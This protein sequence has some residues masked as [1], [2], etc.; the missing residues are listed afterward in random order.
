MSAGAT[1]APASPATAGEASTA[2]AADRAGIDRTVARTRWYPIAGAGDCPPRHVFAGRLLGRE[3]AVWR[4]DDGHV[5]AWEN[6]C[7][8]RG[9]RLTIGVNDG[10]DLVCRYHGWRYASRSA[11][12]TYIPAHPADAPARTIRNTAYPAVERDGL[13]WC[14][15]APVG[16]PP[17]LDDA[18]G[19]D[20][21]ALRPVGI[22][23]SLGAVREALDALGTALDPGAA[24]AEAVQET[25]DAA[26]ARADVEG[27]P[28]FLLQPAAADRT[29]VHGFVRR[30][31][32]DARAGLVALRAHDV[33]L[34]ALRRKVEAD[35][36]RA[37][38][39]RPFEVT[40]SRVDAALAA[41]PVRV[42]RTGAGAEAS[43]IRVRV[44][45]LERT[46]TD[47]VEL[48]LVPLDADG[49]LPA[50]LPGSHVDLHLPNGQ[51][52]QY[53]LANGP[54]TADRWALGVQRA[55]DSRGGSAW[56]HESL[57]EGDVLAASVPRD[58]FAL[59]RD[60][61]DT[62]L[63]A[64]GIGITALAPMALTLERTGLPWRLAYFA[65]SADRFALGAA[66]APLGDRVERLAGLAPETTREAIA[67]RLGE[68]APGRHVY[69]CGPPAMIEAGRELAARAGWPDEAVHFEYFANPD[70]PDAEGAFDVS[71]ARSGVDL[72]VP[73]GT[74]L[75]EALR[76]RDVPVP[77]SCQQGACG[78]CRVRVLDGEVDHRDVWLN[79]S[80][81][82]AN[83]AMMSC[84]SRGRGR[85]VLDL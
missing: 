23:A 10:V 85:L 70:A 73:S 46:A 37:P 63:V 64:G 27:V 81:R 1:A 14:A 33:A 59:R 58:G 48:D 57:R 56:I 53:S 65:R 42:E 78:T 36:A 8:H 61:T 82:R 84:V 32:G 79:A 80:E 52:R 13:V 66:L 49:T 55:P 45:R 2:A 72:H 21:L 39:P 47:V 11:A 68:H 18:F 41:V 19:G 50:A 17:R 24:S 43:L 83:D 12:C 54:G 4:A 5:N 76:S 51:V 71:L 34:R 6:R 77:A 29:I 20:A 35:A 26:L 22:A 38:A 7:L 40:L 25:L 15:E 30:P 28:L 62:L 9:V 67:S 16:E 74:T 44:A 3:L 60:A 69:L 75:L 31:T